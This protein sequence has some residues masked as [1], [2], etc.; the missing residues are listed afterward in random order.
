M[1]W[2]K[3]FDELNNERFGGKLPQYTVET[4]NMNRFFGMCY[5]IEKII[6]LD[7]SKNND[8]ENTLLHEMI[9]AEMKRKG[10]HRV[11]HRKIFWKLLVEKGGHI[12]DIDKRVFKKSSVVACERSK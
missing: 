4:K 1:N 6:F 12:T 11:S 2:Q 10:Y 9:H 7:L 8:V 5:T 3:R